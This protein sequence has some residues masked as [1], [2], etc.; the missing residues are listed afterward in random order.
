MRLKNI[1]CFAYFLLPKCHR[2][3]TW[4]LG[5]A[6]LL[7]VNVS[8]NLAVFNFECSKLNTSNHCGV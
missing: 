5:Y 7:N 2:K 3:P 4:F 1:Y 6:I 8:Y